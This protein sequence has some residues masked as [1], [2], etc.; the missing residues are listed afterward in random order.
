[1]RKYT[2]TMSMFMSEKDMLK[3][4]AKFYEGECLRLQS[5]LN[6]LKG[7]SDEFQYSDNVPLIFIDELI[8]ESE[9]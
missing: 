9:K 7:V 5:I 3:D 6:N 8:E 2:R 4:K 1:M